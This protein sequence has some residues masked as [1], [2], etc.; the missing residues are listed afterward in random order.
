VS[1][2][3]RFQMKRASLTNNNGI[4]SFADVVFTMFVN[5]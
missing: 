1:W 4:L 3:K 5:E 2:R